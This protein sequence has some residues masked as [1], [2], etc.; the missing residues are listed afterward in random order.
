MSGK[1]RPEPKVA[2]SANDAAAAWSAAVTAGLGVS[3]VPLRLDGWGGRRHAAM[4][5]AGT[6]WGITDAYVAACSQIAWPP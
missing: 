6:R 3:G 4:G 2:I 1:A 5:T